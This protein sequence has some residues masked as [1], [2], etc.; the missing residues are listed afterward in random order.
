[1]K[2]MKRKN[3]IYALTLSVLAMVG[4]KRD[5]FLD[6]N[7]DDAFSDPTFFKNESDLKLYCNGFYNTLPVMDASSDNNS[8]NMVPRTK[9]GFLSGQ[10]IVP[11]VKNDDNNEWSWK[12]ERSVNY[13][14]ARYKRA[15]VG[16]DVKNKYAAEARFFRA[17]YFWQK[18]VRYGDVP[19]FSADLN[20][21][22]P[23]LY[24]PRTPHK[25]VMDSVL[26]DLTF[27][28]ANLPEPGS[29]E[30][31]RLHK[32][33]AATLKARICLWE[34]TYRKY[35]GLGDDQPMI[36]EAANA[37]QI[38]M[39][40]GLYDL[41]TTGHPTTDYY[42]LFIQEE[43]LGNKEAIMPKRFLKDVLMHNLTRQLGEGNNGFSKNFVR[44]F[45]CTDGLPASLSPK[46]KGDDS[47]SAEI[48]NRD[49][50]FAQLIATP[51]FVFQVDASGNKD[52]ITL[53]RIGTS[54]T[55]TGYQRVKGRSS[56]LEQW[57]ANQSTLDLFIFRYAEVLLVYAE[58]KAELNECDQSVID[59]TISR[60]R[61]RVGMPAMDISA[62]VK[63]P[64]SDFPAVSVLIDEIRRERRVELA[65]EGFRRDD[66]LRWNALKLIS[67]PESILGMKLRPEVKAQYPNQGQVKDIVLDAN[68]YIRVYPDITGRAWNDRMNLYPIPTQELTLNP[69]LLPQNGGW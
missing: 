60:L 13:F 57:N 6:L 45:L 37:A 42:N 47:I 21:T 15:A 48:T 65:A 54:V 51:G 14:L 38:V 23:E 58:A 16:D 22:S 24:L 32:Y 59:Q 33:A 55:S 18:V 31:G 69:K 1:M 68:G 53:P 28:V 19:W 3:I 17:L 2:M 67:N 8:D 46:Y 9:D 49:P 10:Y 25:Q 29:A 12:N 56:G 5:S 39:A 4:C 44:S 7:P 50:R 40:S 64:Q 11:I 63:D 36:R 61:A 41:Y 43:L 27:A 34:G 35:H 20:E 66:L 62:L 30:K 52:V 26:A